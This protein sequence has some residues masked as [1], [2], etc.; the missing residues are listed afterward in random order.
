ML[1]KKTAS[2]KLFYGKWPYKVICR[3]EGAWTIRYGS[4]YIQDVING[5]QFTRNINKSRLKTFI[6]LAEPFLIDTIKK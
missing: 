4:S 6:K 1:Y 2:S 3:V 5:K